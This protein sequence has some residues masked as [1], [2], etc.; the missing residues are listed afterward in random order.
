MVEN[1]FLFF[2]IL[3]VLYICLHLSSQNI[4]AEEYYW[5][6]GNVKRVLYLKD[7]LLATFPTEISQKIDTNSNANSNLNNISKKSNLNDNNKKKYS[8]TFIYKISNSVN[9]KSLVND[10]IPKSA[11]FSN[12]KKDMSSLMAL[13]GGI[14]VTFVKDYSTADIDKWAYDNNLL[15]GKKLAIKN[16]NMWVFNTLPGI[17]TL[18]KANELMES[19][20]PKIISVQPDWW[21]R[22]EKK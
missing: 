2:F 14:I 8:K 4:F 11:V 1:K 12:T 22:V 10:S 3:S 6:D 15:K 18:K 17:A 20:D 16:L 21:R 13:P 9:V 7:N 19:G 5:Y